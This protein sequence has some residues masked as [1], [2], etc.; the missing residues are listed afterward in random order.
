MTAY[1]DRTRKWRGSVQIADYS[2]GTQ[3]QLCDSFKQQIK[4]T[5]ITIVIQ[6]W[7][8]F[9]NRFNATSTCGQN[10]F[11]SGTER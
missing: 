5:C 7:H 1:L 3:K 4:M 10:I 11:A 6:F 9:Q 8:K 2:T